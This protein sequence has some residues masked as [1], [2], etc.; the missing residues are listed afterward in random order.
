MAIQ[1]EGARGIG[2]RQSPALYGS[3]LLR[4]QNRQS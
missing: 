3:L 1:V 4:A 2:V